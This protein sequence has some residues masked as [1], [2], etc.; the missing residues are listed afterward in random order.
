M[1]GTYQMSFE[2]GKLAFM[3]PWKSLKQQLA[4]HKAKNCVAQKFKL[5]VVQL[6]RCA[7]L[8]AG[9]GFFMRVGAVRERP[10]KPLLTLKSVP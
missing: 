3:E 2:L 6:F 10:L 1:I 4:G 7:V 5:L 9:L 8:P